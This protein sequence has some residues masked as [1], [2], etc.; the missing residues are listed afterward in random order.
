M[1]EILD[2]EDKDDE[3][4]TPRYD[5][6]TSVSSPDIITDL[7]LAEG[8]AG[9]S[10]NFHPQPAHIFHLWRMFLE[11]INPLTKIIHVPTVQPLVAEAATNGTNTPK[12]VEAL[13]FSIYLTAAVSMSD[14]ECRVRLGYSKA[15][16]LE[17]FSKGVRHTL[18]QI[19]ILKFYDLVVLQALVLFM[20]HSALTCISCFISSLLTTE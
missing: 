9:N 17:R 13:L 10:E 11:R 19:G 20:V 6:P 12:N 18:M 14:E 1:K 2:E 3:Y 4:S 5:T 8:G 16:A 7:I 15:E